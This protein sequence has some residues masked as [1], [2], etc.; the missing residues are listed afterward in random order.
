MGVTDDLDISGFWGGREM[1]WREWAAKHYVHAPIC[2]QKALLKDSGT[3]GLALEPWD[4]ALTVFP[5]ALMAISSVA[6]RQSLCRSLEHQGAFQKGGQRVGGVLADT[7]E[8]DLC[9]T[10]TDRSGS[11]TESRNVLALPLD[12]CHRS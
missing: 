5:P 1:I 8:A 12:N 10:L 11:S 2:H 4:S 9:S 3:P 6:S 7:Q